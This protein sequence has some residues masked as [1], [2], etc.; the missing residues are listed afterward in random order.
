MKTIIKKRL[1]S[2]TPKFWKKL[3]N[4][5]LFAGVI[6]TGIGTGLATGGLSIP[7]WIA[8]VV[9]TGG[10]SLAAIGKGFSALTTTD[11]KIANEEQPVKKT[12]WK[13]LISQ[14]LN[15]FKK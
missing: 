7:A 12:D 10:T 9:I 15:I 2:E 14:V 3:G 5:S 11:S 6:L 13:G 4:Y 8:P 1:E